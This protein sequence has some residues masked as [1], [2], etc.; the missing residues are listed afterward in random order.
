MS[1][2]IFAR[3]NTSK[4]EIL[5]EL[6]HKRTPM[7][8][9]NFVGL[10]EGKI[11]NKAKAIGEPYYDGL[12]FHRVINDFMVQ[13]GDPQ[14]SGA[15]GPGYNF[16][17]EFD[18]SLKHDA[19]G[20]LSMANAGPG[21]NGSQFFITHIPTAWLDGKHT[22]FGKV[23]EGMDV[24][25][26]IVQNDVIETLTIERKGGDAENF[27][28]AEVFKSF[29]NKKDEMASNAKKKAMAAVE[30]A[31]NGFEKTASDLRFKITEKGAGVKAE[32]GKNVA[33]H[34]KGMLMDG[35]V[36]D[37]SSQRG[38]PIS[39]KLGEGRVIPGWEES[40]AKLSEGDKARLVIP[41]NLAY[42]SAGAGGVIPPNA[43][44]IFD[45]ELVKVS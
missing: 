15:G 35:T 25:N 1:E 28:A 27:D 30:E 45:V 14:G 17:D 40:I 18:S 34:Y 42:G 7:T 20:V 22:V 3:F 9:A 29:L 19:P 39:F 4:G 31:S 32:N 38:E 41:P 8:V 36:F 43:W 16:P 37:D 26:S 24:V 13:G 33:V 5:V 23:V 10:A 6:F 2:G 12:K 11:E 44:L 21:T